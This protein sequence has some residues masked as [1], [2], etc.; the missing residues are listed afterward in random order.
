MTYVKSCYV[1]VRFNIDTVR[2]RSYN[3]G[4]LLNFVADKGE[5]MYVKDDGERYDSTF[6]S[7]EELH[8]VVAREKLVKKG[9]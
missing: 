3:I 7:T 9:F 2:S 1:R 8:V 4:V 5:Y 6:V